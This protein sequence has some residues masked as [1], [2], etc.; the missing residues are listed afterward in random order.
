MNK[1]LLIGP[2]NK[3][4]V[5]YTGDSAKN[6]FF[7][8]RFREV[9]DK[10]SIVDTW[11]WT[12]RPWILIDLLLKLIYCR[13]YKVVISANS[14]SANK[15]IRI[16][17]LLGHTPNIYYWVIGGSLHKTFEKGLLDWTKYSDI[18]GIFVEGTPMVESMKKLGL[19]NVRCVSNFKK[20][21]YIPKK[22]L[23][24]D[25]KMHF[26]FLSRVDRAKGC[27]Y[28]LE[29]IEILN[30]RGISKEFDVTF[31]GKSTE[32]KEWLDSFKNRVSE[33]PNAVFKGLLDLRKMSNYDVL[34]GY[35]VMLFPTYW[36]G[37]GFPGVI[38]DAYMSS[39]PV[40]ASD[41]NLNRDLVKEGKTGWIIP[42]HNI[43][44]LADKMEYVIKHPSEVR[45]YSLNCGAQ[46][47]EYDYR[48]VLSEENLRVLKVLD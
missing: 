30:A 2:I 35:D 31:Y 41:W 33:I 7:E 18:A 12:K 22:K 37:E 38:I 28:I 24:H 25:D 48:N 46:A 34:A 6:Q 3:G 42:V 23:R 1:V 29:A 4:S 17:K 21:D 40:I 43:S 16:A 39:L 47:F 5:P 11:A 44:A 45:E 27:D 36:D 20:I 8:K 10:V 26:V 19:T 13:G 32:D 14:G 9:F 15:I